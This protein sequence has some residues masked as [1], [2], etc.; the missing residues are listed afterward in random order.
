MLILSNMKTH[1]RI[2]F[3]LHRHAATLNLLGTILMSVGAG[4]ALASLV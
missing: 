3:W 1:Q 2:L 4:L